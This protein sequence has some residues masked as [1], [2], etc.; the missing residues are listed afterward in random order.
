MKERRFSEKGRMIN[1]KS[2]GIIKVASQ[3]MFLMGAFMLIFG[4]IFMVIN[5][6][7][8]D[9]IIMIWIPFMIA[10]VAL[11]L[12]GLL[13]KGKKEDPKNRKM[14]FYPHS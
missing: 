8:S 3:I 5:L 14:H 4:L 13:F 10:G 1:L 6:S 7:K 11:I 2:S 9:S 12:M